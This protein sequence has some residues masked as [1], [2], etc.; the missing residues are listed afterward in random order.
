MGLYNGG[1]GA[2]LS[3]LLSSSLLADARTRPQ[4]GGLTVC[5]YV[6]QSVSLTSQELCV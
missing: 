2:E 6:N 4:S 1:K 3:S 5:G